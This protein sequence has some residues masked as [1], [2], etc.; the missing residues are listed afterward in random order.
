MTGLTA[1]YFRTHDGVRLAYRE[2]GEGLLLIL[3][4]GGTAA[5]RS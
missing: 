5:R 1:A 4:H 2:L 3:I